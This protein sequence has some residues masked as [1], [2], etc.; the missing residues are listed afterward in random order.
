MTVRGLRTAPRET[1]P[2][3]LGVVFATAALLALQAQA[4]DG[5][6]ELEDVEYVLLDDVH[7][8]VGGEGVVDVYFRALTRYRLPVPDL[9]AVDV[10]LLQD[11]QRVGPARV[12]SLR[13]LDEAELGVACVVALDVSRTMMGTPFEE[14]RQ[15]ALRL[16]ER[17][18]PADRAAVVAFSNRVEMVAGFDDE[19]SELAE[20][21][22][23]LEPHTDAMSTRL[24]D[25][26]YAAARLL[27]GNATLPRRAFVVL[28][29]DGRDGGSER[30]AD[31]VVQLAGGGPAEPRIP[32]FTIGYTG[33]G[34]DGLAAL[35]RLSSQTGADSTRAVDLN[36]FYDDV[37]EQIRSTYVMRFEAAMDGAPHDI[38]IEVDGH[39]DERRA[40]YPAV[41]RTRSRTWSPAVALGAA[42]AALVGFVAFGRLRASRPDGR[43]RFLDGPRSDESVAVRGDR[44]RI[45][46]LE[47]NDVAIPSRSVSRFHAELRKDGEQ[48][49]LFDL[50]S[51]N[52]TRLN[53]KR[54]T[55]APLRAGDR[56]RIGD[57]EMVFEAR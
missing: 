26:I 54:I 42:V 2:R 23:A 6:F 5:P 18:S 10:A 17:L 14:A 53:G 28:F 12:T 46:A 16:V 45:G 37:L 8:G 27:R 38:T 1:L 44:V 11:G 30:S 20:Q 19:R 7:P 51:T 9:R 48:W 40:A 32:I 43:L 25:A 50:D 4:A 33:R 22:A 57:V 52:G 39:T 15:A 56:I 31:E 29:T 49:T 41:F 13:R 55:R 36:E 47:E 3:L 21:L 24:Y 35:R 34:Q